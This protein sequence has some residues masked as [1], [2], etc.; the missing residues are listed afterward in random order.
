MKTIK[1]FLALLLS[2]VCLWGCRPRGTDDGG[3]VKDTIIQTNHEQQVNLPDPYAT[4]SVKNF[5]KVIGWKV[6]EFPTAPQGFVVTRFAD[7]LSN[8]RCLY[9]TSSGDV[10]VAEAN[11]EVKGL[12][13]VA[14]ELSAK[15]KSQNLGESANRITILRDKDGDGIAEVKQVLLSKLNQ[16]F[17]MLV[18]G[19]MLYV[20]NTDGIVQFPYYEGQTEIRSSGKK[21]LELPAGGYNNHW[22][23]NIILNRDSSKIFVAVGSASNHGEHGM[24][25][26][27]R[28]A[29]ILEINPDGTAERIF[30]SGLR[31]PVGIALH[32]DTHELYAAVNERDELG[33]DLVPDYLTSVKEGAFYGWPYAYFGKNEDPRLKGLEPGLV[34]TSVV[35]DVSL[36][37]HTASLGLAFNSDHKFPEKYYQG[38]FIGQ[39][40]SWNRSSLVGYKVLF[41]PFKNGKPVGPPEDFLTGFIAS[42]EKSEVYGR[43]VGIAFLRDGSML[44]ADDASNIIWRITY[45]H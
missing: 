4:K 2:L 42:H 5:S 32:P 29:C 3:T 28:R 1:P 24:D 7:G 26:E 9:V 23:R 8:P 19:N 39:H 22:T 38:A 31:N 11:T 13:K 14:V 17:G 20:A 15:A 43:P 25:E 12:K 21:I 10:L 34:A 45:N 40:G 16:P 30:A 35:P 44:V 41:V 37:S 27:K 33:D 6:D 18:L 36:G